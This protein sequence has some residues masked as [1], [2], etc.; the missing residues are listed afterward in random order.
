MDTHGEKTGI[1]AKKG[2][3]IGIGTGLFILIAYMWPTPPSLIEVLEKYGYVEKMIEWE[4]AANAKE[5]AAKT[6]IVL[7]IVPMAVVFFA[8]E[9]L[10]IGVTGIL[11]PLMAYFFGLLPFNM[12]GKTFAGVHVG[13]F[14]P[15]SDGGGG[16]FS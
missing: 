16:G 13:R 14:C 7:G 12:I 15:G 10:P 3:W 9:A 5:A 11:M 8:V 6:M 2:L 1:F 4:I